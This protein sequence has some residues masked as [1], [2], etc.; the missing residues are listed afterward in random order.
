M[1]PRPLLL[2]LFCSLFIYILQSSTQAVTFI[3]FVNLISL[4]HK[5]LSF[6]YS[7]NKNKRQR[8]TAKKINYLKDYDFFQ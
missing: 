3:S 4:T 1:H 8:I 5:L 7:L 6:Q 2:V